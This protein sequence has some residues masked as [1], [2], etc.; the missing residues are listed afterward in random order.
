[1]ET[2]TFKVRCGVRTALFRRLEHLSGCKYLEQYDFKPFFSMI[3][4]DD[5][6]KYMEQHITS[7]LTYFEA[8]AEFWLY[9][10]FG[11]TEYNEEK[12]AQLLDMP[13][14]ELYDTLNLVYKKYLVKEK[15]ERI[16]EDF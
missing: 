4:P 8:C 9:K 12:Y 11:W 10:M 3:K 6:T 13:L 14:F 16:K 15:L 2:D 5:V 1:M 7:Q